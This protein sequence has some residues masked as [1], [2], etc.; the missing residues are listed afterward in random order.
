[1][2][3]ERDN[4]AVIGGEGLERKYQK[5]RALAAAHGLLNDVIMQQALADL[6]VQV[7]S[8]S[9]VAQRSQETLEGGLP[10][11][12]EG[13]LGKLM[14]SQTLQQ[15]SEVVTLILGMDIVVDS[16]A[17]GAFTWSQHVLGAPGF[18]IAGGS[19]E[20]QRTI[21]ADRVLGLPKGN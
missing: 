1:L 10:P 7:R 8:V 17:W 9:L 19:D 15:M 12:P 14:W 6:Y 13:S 2:K 5:V 3:F 4:S 21:I 16:G 11:G 18:R 20:I